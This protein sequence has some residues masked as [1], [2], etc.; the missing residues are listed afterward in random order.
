M[1][2][3]PNISFSCILVP[4]WQNKPL[5]TNNFS[6]LQKAAAKGFIRQQANISDA[7]CT[8]GNLDTFNP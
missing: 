6:E 3:T 7:A 5:P 8:T 4:L 2:L 1:N